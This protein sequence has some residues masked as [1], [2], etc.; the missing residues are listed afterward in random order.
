MKVDTTFLCLRRKSQN[1]VSEISC[2]SSS[3]SERR[4]AG[5]FDFVQFISYI[6]F[7]RRATDILWL[8]M[9]RLPPPL[10]SNVT[11]RCVT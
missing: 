8:S 4:F 1:A 3:V 9:V 10:S 7:F 11:D 6:Q 2:D 5:L